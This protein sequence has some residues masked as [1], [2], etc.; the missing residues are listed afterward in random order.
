VDGGTSEADRGY[1]HGGRR[2]TS[3]ADTY[4]EHL[5]MNNDKRERA[6]SASAE[7]PAKALSHSPSRP[8]TAREGGIPIELKPDPLDALLVH[9]LVVAAVAERE[10]KLEGKLKGRKLKPRRMAEKA[11][12]YWR[13]RG[14]PLTAERLAKWIREEN[15]PENYLVAEREETIDQKVRRQE[16]E[17][18]RRCRRAHAASWG[19]NLCEDCARSLSAVVQMLRLAAG[20][21]TEDEGIRLVQML[22]LAEAEGQPERIRELRADLRRRMAA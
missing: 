3:E 12:A 17:D 10:G 20:Q 21:P 19:P 13:D 1:V 2:G 14:V 11:R 4:K 16:L 7:K 5:T 22:R 18:R 8:G 9:P 15:K 6:T